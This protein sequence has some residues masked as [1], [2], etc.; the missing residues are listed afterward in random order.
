MER[1]KINQNGNYVIIADIHG[2]YIALEAVIEEAIKKYG[3]RL[4]GF[5]FLG[6]YICDY[7]NG[8]KVV[9]IMQELKKKYEFYAIN[10]NRETGMLKKFYEATKDHYKNGTISLEEASKLT[11]WSLD[12]SMGAPLIDCCRLTKDQVEF[13]LDLPESIVL[14]NGKQTFLLEHKTPLAKDKLAFLE[15]EAKKITDIEQERDA[16]LLTAHT[17][18]QNNNKYGNIILFN[19]GSVGLTDEGYPGA[20][21]GELN[22]IRLISQRID[23]DYERAIQELEE[24][25]ILFEKCDKWGEY[26]KLSIQTGFNVAVLYANERNRLTALFKSLQEEKAKRLLASDISF[27][28][29]KKLLP[30]IDKKDKR[31]AINGYGNT[32]PYGGYLEMN[33]FRASDKGVVTIEKKKVYS[34]DVEPPLKKEEKNK[35]DPP[36][37]LISK[38]AR[39]YIEEYLNVDKTYGYYIIPDRTK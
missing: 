22:K 6:D 26:L 36:K 14:D 24:N 34:E 19:P 7:P 28:E 16:I 23:Y 38:L 35:L 15:E 37:E 31:F 10:G 30:M 4:T 27:D 25:E 11:G 8:R 9:E 13:L 12:T 29:I 17:H 32:N 20:Y 5:I 33:L 18:E 39:I 1:Y 3:K 21:Y 2:N